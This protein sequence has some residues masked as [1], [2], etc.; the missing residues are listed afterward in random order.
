MKEYTVSENDAGR[1]LDKYVMNI[2]KKAPSS[3]AY[4]MLRKKNIVLNG[5]KAGGGELLSAG[6]TVVFYLSDETFSKFS[7]GEESAEDLSHL[8]PPILYE[9]DDVLI[10]NKPAGML[11]Q[12]SEGGSISLNEICRSYVKSSE[13]SDAFTPSICN[14]LDRN[15]AGLVIFAKT[16][17]GA[18][19]TAEALRARTI[20]K[21]YECV[22]AGTVSDQMHLSGTLSKN[23][24]NNTVSVG[25]AEDE[26]SYIETDFMPVETNKNLS[27]LCVHLITG[28]THQIRAHLASVGHPVIG[29]YKYGDRKVNDIYKREFGISSQLL[30]CNR[31]SFPE[32]FGIKGLAGAECETD[33]PD[34]FKKVMQ[35]HGHQEGSA[36]LRSRNS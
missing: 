8:L 33:I 36:A 21:F 10:V 2:L 11:S 27:R 4:K 30:V 20:G 3:F 12:K 25:K 35:W 24:A 22:V 17:R 31:L 6:D 16:Y 28:K 7:S 18:K 34:D 1:R 13:A 5:K 32:D 19:I 26:G 23:S 14:R 15:T 9:D 29:D